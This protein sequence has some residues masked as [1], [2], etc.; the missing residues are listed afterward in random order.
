MCPSFLA[1]FDGDSFLSVNCAPCPVVHLYFNREGGRKGHECNAKN[2]KS[3]VSLHGP[4]GGRTP[5]P[6]SQTK[7][8]TQLAQ[9]VLRLKDLPAMSSCARAARRLTNLPLR[10]SPAS[11]KQQNKGFR[12]PV[13]DLSPDEFS[14]RLEGILWREPSHVLFVPPKVN[15]RCPSAPTNDPLER[16]G[17]RPINSCS[18]QQRCW[19]FSTDEMGRAAGGAI[20]S[21]ADNVEPLVLQKYYICGF[22]FTANSLILVHQYMLFCFFFCFFLVSVTE[23]QPAAPLRSNLQRKLWC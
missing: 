10:I 1:A 14:R 4:D 18:N 22:N 19:L 15:A 7:T 6:S 17:S 23:L 9:C 3:S 12:L 20:I 16:S 13:N 8:G 21:V 2:V 5:S 11:C